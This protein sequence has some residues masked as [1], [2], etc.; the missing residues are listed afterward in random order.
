MWLPGL[1]FLLSVA[2][3]AGSQV[4]RAAATNACAVC[5]LRIVWTRSA[6]TH[7]DQW[8]T[9]KHAVYGVGCERC[10]GGD[11]TTTDATAA[12]RGVR[13]SADPASRVNRASLAST[14]GRCHRREADA[15]TGSAHQLLLSK[16]GWAAP[17]CTSC[18]TSMAGDVPSATGLEVTC[19][20]CHGADPLDRPRV[21]R[22][23][24][25]ELATMRTSLTR[26]K[27]E[28]AGVADPARRASL[29]TQWTE[30][31]TSLRAAVAALHEF[32]L[33]AVE[34]RLQGSRIQAEQL[35]AGLM[36]R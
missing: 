33:P 30:T 19:R 17:G 23:A 27:F 6:I 24:R 3:S 28:I 10:H 12:H 29:T 4:P 22:R 2:M 20:Q 36:K 16:G 15:F 34:R 21:A 1:A 31:D 35:K 26:A 8:V 14:C 18:H 13:N 5:H 25:E 32:D 11:A 7:V 9:S